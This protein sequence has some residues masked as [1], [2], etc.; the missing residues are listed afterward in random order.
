[1]SSD[2]LLTQSQDVYVFPFEP[3]VQW[4]EFYSSGEEIQTYIKRTVTKYGLSDNV[5]L[6]SRMLES[7]WDDIR[8]KWKLKIEQ[9]GKIVEDECDIFVSAVGWLK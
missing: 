3:N 5:Q 9:H 8:G 7:V 6:Q 2:G 1:M 4:S